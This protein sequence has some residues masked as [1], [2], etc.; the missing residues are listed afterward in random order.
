MAPERCSGRAWRATPAA[1]ALLAVAVAFAQ[2]PGKA[3]TDTRI[4]L[5]LDAGR[6]LERAAQT[7][8]STGGDLG[9]VQG[10]L[11][12]G[13]LFPTG[14][15]Y[16]L[17]SV[18]GVPVWVGQRLLI[19][20]TLWLAAW[21]VVRLM[22][23]LWG[24][25]RGLA[26]AVAGLAYL[27][28]PYVVVTLAVRGT[29]LLLAY[30]ALPWLVLCV[31]RGLERR[32]SWREPAAFGLLVAASGGAIAVAFTF[33]AALGALAL[34][35]YETRVLRR[36]A[37]NFG[38]FAWR[39][40]AC[41]VAGS[42]W[43]LV[44]LALQG[45]FG[46]DFQQFAEQ[47][48]TIWSTTSLSE[49]FRGLGF[50]VLY[51]GSGYGRIEPSVGISPAYLFSAPVVLATFAVPLLAFGG[52]R[53]TRAWR[54]GPPLGALAAITLLVMAA[55]FP[56]GTPLRVALGVAFDHV[57]SLEVL[58]TTYKAAPV[59]VL[60]VACLAGAAAATIVERRPRLAVALPL[61]VVVTLVLAG[62]PLF[63]GKAIDRQSA[64]GEVPGYW[65]HAIDAVDAAVG[66]NRR[67]LVLPGELFSA[68]RWGYTNT[69]VG[70]AEAS[71]PMVVRQA[72][73]YADPRA[74]QLLDA[75][76]ELVQQGRLVPGQLSPLLRLMGVGQ[77]LVAADGRSS[78]SGALPAGALPA[79][80]EGQAAF[81]RPVEH[82][83]PALGLPALPGRSGDGA[84]LPA[85]ERYPVPGSPGVVRLLP[86][87]RATVVE[88][89]AVGLTELAAH[90][91][92]APGR[93]LSY[94]GDLGRE[95]L[96]ARLRRGA[97]LVFTDSARRRL[98][99]TARVR[100][101]QGP[102]LEGGERLPE[103]SAQFDLFPAAGDRHRTV[104]RHLGAV[105]LRSPGLPDVPQYPEHRPF[106]AFDGDPDTSWVAEARRDEERWVEL[107][108]PSPRRIPTIAVTGLSDRE[109]RTAAVIVTVD[110]GP[111][112]RVRL[113][114]R[115]PT[116]I[117][118]G[119]R[120]MRRL[121]IRIADVRP[122]NPADEVTGG[123][124]E[125]RIPGL[126]IRERLV[127]PVG[128]ARAARGLPL[129]RTPIS[130]L[131]V[132]TT[133]DFPRRAGSV[134]RAPL[135]G[136]PRDMVDAETGLER[137]IELPAAR[138]FAL[139][140]WASVRPAAPDAAI[141]ALAGMPPAWHFASTPWFEGVPG[142]RASSAFDG[143]PATA[144][145]G[146]MLP[147]GHPRLSIRLAKPR[148]V[149]RLAVED[150]G[151]RFRRAAR[152][153]VRMGDEAVD[154]DV[155][156]G[157][158]VRLSRAVRGRTLS[159]EVLAMRPA[160]QPHGQ[161]AAVAI[162]EIRVPGLRVPP[163]RRVG[164]FTTGCHAFQAQG[165]ET[166]AQ[167]RVSGRL[168]DLDAARPL[169][170]RGCSSLGLRAGTNVL[171][172][173]QGPAFRADHLRL[174]SGGAGRA[175]Q[176]PGR[177]LD[178]G[179]GQDGRR[180]GVHLALDRPGWLVLGESYSRGWR[181]WC[182]DRDGD[183]RELG[184]PQPAAGFANGWRIGPRC[185]AARFAFG[186]QR[187]A[188]A[189][190]GVSAVVV[191]GLLAFLALTWRPAR[192]RRRSAPQAV[193]SPLD[194]IPPSVGL[195]PASW[196][197]ALAVGALVALVGGFVFAL[198]AGVVLG[199]AAVVVARLGPRP[200]PLLAVTAG[201]LGAI[202][203]VYL[204]FPAD[205]SGGYN[206]G[207][208]LHNLA[209]HW[210]AVIALCCLALACA[211]DIRGRRQGSRPG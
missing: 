88:G 114:T 116:R 99:S 11:L 111:E 50:W 144:W 107:R 96:R 86:A 26:H 185:V 85:L 15:W 149:R 174:R 173:P 89:D 76:D 178:A 171:S 34:G 91:A 194:P 63:T 7:W 145:A 183:E 133:A 186:P 69:S 45:G 158:V 168:E 32:G 21:G 78:R 4:E 57:R 204:T 198:R 102:T 53:W 68:Y 147:R 208:A 16:E 95:E 196:R 75:T 169:R 152:V 142:R 22:D 128:L 93:P 125:V 14:P 164:R 35:L 207:F 18:A 191:L 104:A 141:D 70:P 187:L 162:A 156:R 132:R 47:P 195:R 120:R 166:R 131:L 46:A 177:V 176:P 137:Q 17:A 52:L 155:G 6:F 135:A 71:N 205:D 82:F 126:R 28:S 203:L 175:A 19:A 160:R 23:A 40:I 38:A 182:R 115:G 134:A 165:P 154:A 36:S 42:L 59:L 8:S 54:Y 41:S 192:R 31:H 124:R 48:S 139:D 87:E 66:P 94:A 110:G 121:R 10:G 39:A 189:G 2:R 60:V 210:L 20:L 197:T 112:R 9:H 100:N 202:P 49:S 170:L 62:L 140:G 101:N 181:A 51:A 73:R 153:R 90:G 79:A 97:E 209:G 30:A 122:T 37:G 201:V 58:R 167:V 119:A 118:L 44:P 92:L 43:W 117:A 193:L 12:A 179:R 77:V 190:Y 5:S 146:A 25:P 3:F 129:R 148:T 65:N 1:L 72:I 138:R 27:A 74:A 163:P 13:Y 24:G 199:P 143:D 136:A 103:G 55:G 109:A 80:L 81:R 98:L 180:D 33:W 161:L 150:G 211:L 188:F 184:A 105:S 151:P 172:V 123:L 159:L 29:A 108:L 130:V 83:G 127:T 61:C 64:Y 106:A 206:F 200:R 67:S 157:G 84:R 56:P 113:R